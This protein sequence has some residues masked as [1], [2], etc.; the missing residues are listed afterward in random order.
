MTPNN[1]PRV[2]LDDPGEIDRFLAAYRPADVAEGTWLP[3]VDETSAL[4][5]R[6]GALSRRRVEKDIQALGAV[7]VHLVDR[8]RPATLAEALSDTTLLSYDATLVCGE[9][10]RE[11][12][13]GILRRLQAVHRGVPWRAQRRADGARIE[14]MVQPQ[15]VR[16]LQRVVKAA[17]VASTSEG[18]AALLDA[19][20]SARRER[21]GGAPAAGGPSWDQARRF[22]KAHGLHLT[23]P[24]L[25]AIVV[26]EVLD[27][28]VPAVLLVFD[29]RL[30][31]R[32]LDLA[33]TRVMQ[34]PH[35][36][37]PDAR[38]AL[39]GALNGDDPVQSMRPL[40]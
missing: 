24:I 29:F 10:T 7:V 12:K 37:E 3:L 32:D 34:L 30:S 36:P 14:T 15:A 5:R 28:A 6:A 33:L 35:V 17:E 13:R 4:V 21:A 8:G 18:A 38:A 16:D 1:P 25:R 2:A 26:H 40:G 11:N 19:V 20:K 23:K 22:A 27:R 39:R 9:K 31:R